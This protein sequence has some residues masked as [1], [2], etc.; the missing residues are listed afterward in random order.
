MTIQPRYDIIKS[1][2]P[3]PTDAPTKKEDEQ[4]SGAKITALYCR[5]S[6]E[7]ERLGE[8]TSIENQKDILL[9]FAKEK[10]EY[11]APER[12]PRPDELSSETGGVEQRFRCR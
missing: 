1:T 5:L 2:N 8:S 11:S 10:R 12:A 4:M 3:V 9:T 7:D 6:Q